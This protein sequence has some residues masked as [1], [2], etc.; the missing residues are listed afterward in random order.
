[1]MYPHLMSWTCHQ[2]YHIHHQRYLF[3]ARLHHKTCYCA[4]VAYGLMSPIWEISGK[5][6]PFV[7]QSQ[8]VK[9][10]NLW[11]NTKVLNCQCQ[12][13]WQLHILCHHKIPLLQGIFTTFF[14]FSSTNLKQNTWFHSG[15]AALTHWR[16]KMVSSSFLRSINGDLLK[17]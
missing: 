5:F 2:N 15:N 4:A 3:Q 11:S 13:R 1:M 16:S 9:W 6:E 10:W 17:C 14:Q 12:G 7:W 8:N